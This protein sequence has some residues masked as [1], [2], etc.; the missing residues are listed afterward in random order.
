MEMEMMAPARARSGAITSM[1]NGK[2]TICQGDDNSQDGKRLRYSG[3]D[4]PDDIWYH[5]HSLMPLRDAAHAACVSQAFLRSWRCYPNLIL[6]RKSMGLWGGNFT[7]IVDHILKNHSGIGVKKLQIFQY[8]DYNL[9]TCYLDNWLHIAI[10]PGI[11]NITLL[12]PSNY[13]FPCSLLSGRNGIS[14]RY[15]DLSN[16]TF[17]PTVGLGCMRSLTKLI[18]SNVRIK[19]DELVCL[20]SKSFALKQLE[21]RYCHMIICLKIPCLP[22]QLSLL[23]VSRCQNLK[24]IES[25]PPN[26]SAFN[27]SGDIV[28][29]SFGQSS[30]V[31]DLDMD[32]GFRVPNFLCYAITKIPYIFPNLR[33]LTLSSFNERLNTPM[34]AAKFLHVKHLRIYLDPYGAIPPGYDYFSLVSFLDACPVLETFF[35]AV[36]QHCIKHGSIFGN[37]SHMTQ[38]PE[39]KHGS[40]KNVMILGFCSAKSMIEL[41]CHI[42]EN[43]TSLESIALDTIFDMNDETNIGRCS[44]TSA[45]EIGKCT[46][47]PRALILEAHSGL[48]AIESYVRGKVPGKV[49]LTVRGPCSQCHDL[50]HVDESYAYLLE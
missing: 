2:G 17:H 41:A 48:Q 22:E 39:H 20:L 28:Q 1:T 29:L 36:T 32:D 38:V 19:D 50:E 13:S 44:T 37:A 4:I 45:G 3:P 27:F 26:L 40:L 42:L 47:L 6:T 7:I 12:L 25:K 21:L 31:K 8:G 43:A 14:I 11:E 15:L 18:L 49:E 46:V 35:L 9:N 16:G 34:V 30:Q 5:I 10:T 23:I 33:S 24:M